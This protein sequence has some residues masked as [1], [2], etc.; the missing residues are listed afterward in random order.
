MGLMTKGFIRE[1]RDE[2][3]NSCNGFG[4]LIMV[5]LAVLKLHHGRFTGRNRMQLG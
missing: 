5:G 3:V 4:P 1:C 2:N